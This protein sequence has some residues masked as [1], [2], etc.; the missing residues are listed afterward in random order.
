MPLNFGR[1][2]SRF[3]SRTASRMRH[4]RSSWCTSCST[5]LRGPK[6]TSCPPS[7]RSCSRAATSLLS[8]AQMCAFM[9]SY[10]TS[11]PSTQTLRTRRSKGSFTVEMRSRDSAASMRVMS[12]SVCRKTSISRSMATASSADLDRLSRCSKVLH[13]RADAW[14]VKVLPSIVFSARNAS[15]RRS[16]SGSHRFPAPGGG[17][18]GSKRSDAFPRRTAR[19]SSVLE[20]CALDW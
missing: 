19:R 1:A 2:A 6:G 16:A 4:W 20:L 7:S 3:A 12:G 14:L 17:G 5:S 13:T 11:G 18:G 10:S 15:R 8:T 9:R